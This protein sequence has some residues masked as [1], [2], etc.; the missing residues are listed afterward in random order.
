MIKLV[1]KL[2]DWTSVFSVSVI[3]ASFHRESILAGMQGVTGVN[4]SRNKIRFT[5]Y[6]ILIL[7]GLLLLPK[8]NV[9]FI[10]LNRRT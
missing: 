4:V 1:P 5:P 10:F 3:P 2:P 9:I 7:K 8:R 6:E